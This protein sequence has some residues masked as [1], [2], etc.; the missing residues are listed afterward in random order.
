MDASA[1]D[2]NI[3]TPDAPRTASSSELGDDVSNRSISLTWSENGEHEIE[4]ETGD[5]SDSGSVAGGMDEPEVIHGSFSAD[6]RPVL[7]KPQSRFFCYPCMTSG[8][9][10]TYD[11]ISAS[12]NL[13]GNK[14]RNMCAW[15]PEETDHCASKFYRYY[16]KIKEHPFWTEELSFRKEKYLDQHKFKDSHPESEFDC[17]ALAHMDE[18]E[19]SITIP[20]AGRLAQRSNLIRDKLYYITIMQDRAYRGVLPTWFDYLHEV[21]HPTKYASEQE[22]T[23]DIARSKEK[24]RDLQ[25]NEEFAKLKDPVDLREH[26]KALRAQWGDSTLSDNNLIDF[27]PRILREMK[28]AE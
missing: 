9:N 23:I 7:S 8:A 21:F 10:L 24:L 17:E 22:F 16:E 18:A 1:F 4:A 5:L 14:Y 15:T 20:Q 26:R 11:P 2:D 25:T 6:G 28:N 19:G 27:D 13:M 3:R 12:W